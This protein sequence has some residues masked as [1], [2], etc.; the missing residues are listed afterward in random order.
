MASF[1]FILL[2]LNIVF[3]AVPAFCQDSSQ[4]IAGSNIN[5]RSMQNGNTV[6]MSERKYNKGVS[7]AELKLTMQEYSGLNKYNMGIRS[8]AKFGETMPHTYSDLQK[9]YEIEMRTSA[10]GNIRCGCDY[11]THFVYKGNAPIV[12]YLKNLVAVVY[13]CCYWL[14]ADEIEYRI[15]TDNWD[16]SRGMF[17]S[18][19]RLKPQYAGYNLS[20]EPPDTGDNSEPPIYP[21]NGG[22]NTGGGNT[23]GGDG[24]DGAGCHPE[25]YKSIANG[26]DINQNYANYINSIGAR[27]TGFDDGSA[28]SDANNQLEDVYNKN[29]KR[30]SVKNHNVARGVNK[31]GLT[32]AQSQAKYGDYGYYQNNQTDVEDAVSKG[33]PRETASALNNG[34]GHGHYSQEQQSEAMAEYIKVS[35]PSAYEAASRGDYD[36]AN[37]KLKGKWFSLDKNKSEFSGTSGCA[38]KFLTYKPGESTS[39]SG[40][41]T[42]TGTTGAGAP[43]T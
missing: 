14:V 20:T 41:T 5:L 23:G 25:K 42:N 38:N 18:R 15:A 19:L 36:T 33:V 31:E 28:N 26:K 35:N 16:T 13:D 27:E 39:G 22:G 7:P 6:Q 43:G 3:I 4:N 10:S 2:I 40:G 11:E 17:D 37:S 21:P 24:S 9:D 30:T 12:G 29:G 32:L 8:C 34:G 1:K